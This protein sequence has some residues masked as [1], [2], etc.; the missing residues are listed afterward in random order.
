[1]CSSLRQVSIHSLRQWDEELYDHHG[2]PHEWHNLA[3]D[4]RS[5]QIKEQLRAW[6]PEHDAKPLKQRKPNL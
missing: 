5:D 1:M 6:L 2:D 4:S 3:S